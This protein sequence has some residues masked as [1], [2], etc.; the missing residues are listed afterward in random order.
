M[1]GVKGSRCVRV[2]DGDSTG[3]ALLSLEV[4]DRIL[5]YKIQVLTGL[6]PFHPLRDAEISFK[7][8]E[9]DRPAKPTNASDVGIS[10]GLWQLLVRCWNSDDTK[11]PRVEEIFQHLC[12]EPARWS[13]FPPSRLLRP[14]SREDISMSATHKHGNSQRFF[15]ACSRAHPSIDDIFH[16]AFT[17]SVQTPTEGMR[18]VTS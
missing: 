5:K 18:V 11:R 7:V 14:P 12:Q 2:R 15:F 10:D 4:P 8:L 6:T 16:T 17:T 3:M 13:I 9:G 1:S